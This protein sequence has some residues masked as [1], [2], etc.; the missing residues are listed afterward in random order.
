MVSSLPDSPGPSKPKKIRRSERYELLDEVGSGGMG[1]V[2]RALDRELNRIVAVKILNTDLA[3]DPSTL[4]RLKREIVLATRVTEEH[5]VRVHD[6]GEIGGRPLIVMDW[7]KGETLARLL[8]R[9]HTLPPSQVYAFALQIGCALRAIH[10]AG[11]VHRDLK[12]GNI[13]VRNDGKALVTDFGLAC[14]SATHDAG[15]HQPG[16][17]RGTPAYMAPEQLAG[18]PADPRSDLYAFGI[19]LLE[20]LTDTTALEPLAPLR[21]RWLAFQGSSYQR[22]AELQK[23]SV[24]EHVIRR[25][26]QVDRSER[27]SNADT[28]VSEM[29]AAVIAGQESAPTLVSRFRWP[30][31]RHPYVRI[32]LSLVLVFLVFTGILVRKAVVQHMLE[33]RAATSARAYAR[34][35]SQI[36]ADGSEAGW[37]LGLA[38]LDQALT[39]NPNHLPAFRAR[40]QL[41]LQL[42]EETGEMEFLTKAEEESQKNSRLSRDERILLR[43]RINVDAGWYGDAVRAL[44]AES[45]LLAASEEANILLGRAL[46][47]AGQ[48]EQAAEAYR[49][50]LALSPESWRGHQGYGEVLL[51]SGRV[52]DARVEFV[53]VTRLQPNSMIGYSRLGTALLAAAD[54]KGARRQFETALERAPAAEA[55]YNL[56]LVSYYGREYAASIPFFEES[57]RIRPNSDRYTLALADVLHRLKRNEQA[58]E[59]Y[60]RVL[61]LLE[62]SAES[63]PLTTDEECRR[64]IGFAR[65]GDFASAREVLDRSDPKHPEVAFARATLALVEGRLTASKK[66]LDE[67][68]RRGYPAM[69]LDLDPAF[70]YLP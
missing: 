51:K 30:G 6:I 50:A 27:Y 39:A 52:Q 66:Y 10:L 36:A 31:W 64:A 16:D 11:I 70:D 47:A 15:F 26:L 68:V 21:L 61:T 42:Y 34:A 3:A 46:A 37:R 60:L 23:L 55:Y 69:Q 62:R 56:G 17:A 20:M 67:A 9:V 49:Q 2:Y 58:R 33:I 48:L 22:T 4:L 53:R 32:V 38:S 65:L 5:V 12:P 1:T 35:M 29:N 63:R 7:V 25:C 18:L 41:L 40:L 54:L 19:I 8:F 57:I 43:A 13:L 45:R 14:S 59:A 44:Q 24:L 28:V